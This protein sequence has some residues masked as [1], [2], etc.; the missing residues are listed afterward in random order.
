MSGMRK[1]TKE[2]YTEVY[3]MYLDGKS[4]DEIREEAN[5]SYSTIDRAMRQ[6]GATFDNSNFA[7]DKSG[8]VHKKRKEEAFRAAAEP[9]EEY[10]WPKQYA[11][12]T[13]RARHIEIRGKHYIDITDWFM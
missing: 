1:E 8:K 6:F 7:E 10:P 4:R 12:D 3:H 9:E 13:R 11:K 2:R 5:C